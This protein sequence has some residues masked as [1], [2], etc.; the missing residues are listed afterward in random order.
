MARGVLTRQSLAANTLSIGEARA[1]VPPQHWSAVAW[2][3][4][5]LG[6]LWG[7]QLARNLARRTDMLLGLGDLRRE[8]G[9]RYVTDPRRPTRTCRD[10]QPCDCT[11]RG[12]NLDCGKLFRHRTT[13]LERRGKGVGNAGRVGT[14]IGQRALERHARAVIVA[15]RSLRRSDRL[16]AWSPVLKPAYSAGNCGARLA[17][18][19]PWIAVS[20]CRRRRDVSAMACSQTKRRQ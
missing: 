15:V 13:E 5:T 11:A 12:R 16:R 20:Q 1:A 2:Q 10:R 8:Y 17:V 18:E 14:S 7:G 9:G 3:D 4:S 19:A 6:V